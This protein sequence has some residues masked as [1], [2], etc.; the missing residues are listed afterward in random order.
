MGTRFVRGAD[1]PR[2]QRGRRRSC[3]CRPARSASPGG[4]WRAARSPPPARARDRSAPSTASHSVPHNVRRHLTPP[5][6]R[7]T[8]TG[9]IM[10]AY[11]HHLPQLDSEGFLTDGGIET[12]L[13]YDDGLRAPGF[14]GVHAAQRRRPGGRRWSAT[15]IRTPRSPPATG[16]GSSWKQRRGGRA[17]TGVPGS[18]TAP[19]GSK[20]PTATPSTCS[21]PCASA[22]RPRP[23]RL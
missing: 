4:G 5:E 19:R 11:R 9:E 12:T 1:R 8:P 20:P 18:A 16:S 15:S 2:R 7:P 10:A 3:R 14:R 6:R 23:L 13:I 17:W 21:S 22:T